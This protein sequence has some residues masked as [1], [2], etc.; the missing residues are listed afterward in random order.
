MGTYNVNRRVKF[1]RFKEGKIIY[2]DKETGQ[3]ET[4]DGIRGLIQDVRITVENFEGEVY[5]QLAINLFDGEFNN[6]LC[7]RLNSGYAKAFCKILPNI[8]LNK[9]VEIEGSYSPIEG[10]IRHA[11]GMFVLQDKKFVKWYFTNKL[12]NG[13][14]LKNESLPKDQQYDEQLEFF[15]QLLNEVYWKLNNVPLEAR[16]QMKFP[17]IL[18]NIKSLNSSAAPVLTDDKKEVAEIQDAENIAQPIDDLPF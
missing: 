13:M 10:S 2:K 12:P 6:I 11:S 8:D 7:M 14:P 4:S 16:G 18:Q 17:P 3:V 9:I 1:F 5:K 15:E